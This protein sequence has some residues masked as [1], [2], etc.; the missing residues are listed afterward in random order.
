MKI[1]KNTKVLEGNK[2]IQTV[3]KELPRYTVSKVQAN[4]WFNSGEIHEYLVGCLGLHFCLPNW[5]RSIHEIDVSEDSDTPFEDFKEQVVAKYGD[6]FKFCWVHELRHSGSSFSIAECPHKDNGQF[7]V[8]NWD[9]SNVGFVAIPKD[10]KIELSTIGNMLTDLWEGSIYSY[11]VYDNF[12]NEV[13]ES[14]EYWLTTTSR[15]EWNDTCKEAQE[16]YGVDL[17]S[18]DREEV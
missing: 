15:Q 13:V 18:A 6:K 1:I 3:V 14:Y 17:E 8:Q 9:T 4:Y 2:V 11:D 5:G 12:H 10:S 7:T 16:T